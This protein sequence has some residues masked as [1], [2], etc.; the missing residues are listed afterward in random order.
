MGSA[1]VPAAVRYRS[2]R[3]FGNRQARTEAAWAYALIAPMLIGFSIFFLIALGASLALSFTQWRIIES[4][5]WIGL[6]NFRELAHD[7]DFRTALVNTL[8]ITIPHVVL[9]LT[10]ALALAIALN[11]RIRYQAFYRLLFFL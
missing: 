3:R 5:S 4:P 8:A 1:E 6:G 9:R 10:I 11:S 7:P 2:A